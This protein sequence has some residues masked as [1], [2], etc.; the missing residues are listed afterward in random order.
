VGLADSYLAQ[1]IV[2]A[3]SHGEAMPRARELAQRALDIDPD[4]PEAHAMIG[5]VA[6][7]Y[8]YD[9]EEAGRRFRL[10]VEREPLSTHLRSWH[11]FFYLICIG[12]L[13]EARH[14]SVRVL[15]DD[16]L[17]Q[18][19]HC[20]HASVLRSLGFDDEALD[21]CRKSV[22]L[23]SE[24]WWGHFN[25]GTLC[26]VGGRHDEALSCAE[27]ANARAPWSAPTIGL[28]A[29]ALANVGQTAKAQSVLDTLSDQMPSAQLGRAWNALCRGDRDGAI[30]WM[31]KAADQRTASLTNILVRPFEPLLRTSAGWPALLKQ[32]NLTGASLAK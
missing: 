14:Q 23:D 20:C 13:D 11:S 5:I 29:A 22:E 27:E 4:L 17:G 2:G 16:P 10:A 6:G 28:L 24:F 8:D 7:H 19:W 26:A 21:A 12:R 3:I 1:G 30:E 18:I 25:L 15:E 31:R 32:L 9:W